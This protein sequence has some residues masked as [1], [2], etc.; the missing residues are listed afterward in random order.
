ML[1][2]Y[3]ID[4][5]ILYRIFQPFT[6]WFQKQTGKTTFFWARIF[7]WL[8][9]FVLTLTVTY[10]VYR[11]SGLKTIYWII[12]IPSLINTIICILVYISLI[13]EI[14]TTILDCVEKKTVNIFGPGFALFRIMFLMLTVVFLA[15]GIRL[16]ILKDLSVLL[17]AVGVVMQSITG[18]FLCCTPLPPGTGGEEENFPV[19]A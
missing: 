16:F 3:I 15:L 1:I 10:C 4:A 18:Y 5:F 11:M 9:I 8:A 19:P 17:Y 13:P 2:F 14:E 6:E 7:L 12:A